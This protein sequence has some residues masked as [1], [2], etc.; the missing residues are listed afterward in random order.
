MDG[1]R[2]DGGARVGRYPRGAGAVGGGSVRCR[3]GVGGEEEGEECLGYRREAVCRRY[4]DD[5]LWC[6]DEVPQGWFGGARSRVDVE[7]AGD[8][9]S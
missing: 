7:L 5:V 2:G 8:L 4:G 9:V 1:G 6:P 3:G